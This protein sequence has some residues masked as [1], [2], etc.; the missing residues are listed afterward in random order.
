MQQEQPASYYASLFQ[1]AQ[2]SY[3]AKLWTGRYFRY[4]TASEYK[5]DVQADQFAGQWYATTSGLGD[6]VPPNMRIAALRTIFALNVMKFAGGQLGA[7][8]GVT[9]DGQII[10]TNEQVHEV[11]TGTTF[12]LAATMLQAG[13]RDEAFRTVHGLYDVI[14]Q[15]KGYWFRTPEAWDENAMYR[16]SM[17]MRPAA[18]WAMEMLRPP[19]EGEQK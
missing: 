8:N 13:M 15:S 1:R 12:A 14:Y 18:V 3:I 6:L 19:A 16:A 10:H 2:K 11:W 9:A 4:D 7:I 5:D 17:Y